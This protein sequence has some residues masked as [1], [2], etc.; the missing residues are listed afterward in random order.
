MKKFILSMLSEDGAVSAM[1]FC[2]VLW[3]TALIFAWLI[4]CLA[5]P[6]LPEIPG[7]LLT[8]SGLMLG[9]KVAQKVTEKKS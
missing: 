4:V 5:Q 6:G 9:G 8:F 1:R 3:F 2:M 7:S